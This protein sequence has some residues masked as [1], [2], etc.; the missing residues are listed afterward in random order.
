MA[1]HGM[2]ASVI[3]TAVLNLLAR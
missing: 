1:Q 3:L 2:E